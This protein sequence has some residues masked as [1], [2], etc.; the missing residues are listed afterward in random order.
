MSRKIFCLLL[1]LT[2]C[3]A[4][5]SCGEETPNGPSE[6]TE[7]KDENNDFVCDNC[8]EALACEHKDENKDLL[9]DNCA[10]DVECEHIDENNDG[11][12][13][14]EACGWD[15]DHEH[16]Y[17]DKWSSDE[18]GHRHAPTCDHDIDSID[19][20]EHTD[21]D[22]DG[23]CDVCEYETCEHTFDEEN[24]AKNETTHWHNSTCGHDVYKNEAE[25]SDR[26]GNGICYVCGYVMC[27]HTFDEE[28]WAKDESGHWH[29][30]SC[31]HDSVKSA[32]E[33]HTFNDDEICTVCG[34]DNLHDHTFSADWSYDKYDHWH[35][36]T[37]GHPTK[38]EG[39]AEHVDEN[40]DGKCEVC[41]HQFCNHSFE[42]KYSSNDVGHWIKATCGCEADKPV[43]PHV[44][45][46]SDELGLCDY[47]DY[48][49]CEH[50]FTDDWTGSDDT[51][52]WKDS[53]CGHNVK[54]KESHT[55][56]ADI[57]LYCDICGHPYDDPNAPEPD[58]DEDDVITT[59][60]D[61]IGDNKPK[62]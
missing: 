41:E 32:V 44:D 62:E 45:E 1:A 27:E 51:H 42:T 57:N 3:F 20:E 52:H 18:E 60:P 5:W 8:E 53:T 24:W 38:T 43:E 54:E 35:A 22:N 55:D 25:H 40:K 31:G 14:I 9:C 23:V 29:A 26:Y 15:Y 21:Q 30:A 17:S 13:D 48:E 2:L 34:Y 47:C 36:S 33:E 19:I 28:N 37:C 6:C 58:F 50:T 10:A 39:R 4:L 46:D 56:L 49:M 61:Y 11:I 16:T 12:C 59:P 7:H